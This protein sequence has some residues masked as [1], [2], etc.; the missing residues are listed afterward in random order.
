MKITSFRARNFRGFIDTSHIVLKPI[1]LLVGKNSIGKSS[2]ARLWPIFNQGSKLQKRSPVIWNGDLVDFGSFKNVLS[3]HTEEKEIIFEFKIQ[4][5][6]IDALPRKNIIKYRNRVRHLKSGEIIL[7]MKLIAGADESSTI[8]SEL[9]ISTHG[10]KIIYKFNEAGLL[11]ETSCDTINLKFTATYTQE[12]S[13]G[14]LIPITEFFVKSND[15]LLLAWSPMR[16][17]LYTFLRSKL[18]GRLADERIHEICGKLN[19]CGSEKDLL[20]YCEFLP[21]Q[22]KTWQD[23]LSLL[24]TNSSILT[25]FHLCVFLAV[26]ELLIRD[27][28]LDLHQ[29]FS[30]VNYIRPLRATAQRYYRRQDLAVDNIDSE[31][32]NL[33]FFLASLSSQKL[34]KLNEWLEE[35]IDVRVKLDGEQGHVMVTLEDINTGRVDNMADMGFGFSQ[36]L[37]LAV[38]AWISS[39]PFA[40]TSGRA[41]SNNMILVWEQPELHLHP[42]MQRKLARLIAKTIEVDAKK[43][44]SFIIETHS[45]SIINELGDLIIE[46]ESLSD[47]IQILIFDQIDKKETVISKTNFDTNGQLVDWPIGFLSV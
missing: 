16:S 2:F 21:Y 32:A 25:Q 42:A 46:D 45:Q 5:E 20:N 36:V 3:R 15:K 22:Y 28:D 4:I 19:V 24:R 26:S 11:L 31:G 6:E 12:R 34:E 9:S 40:K 10:L 41:T 1:N 7:Q 13:V 14:F 37:P 43:K 33:A 29:Y 18:H 44:V 39:S 8:C 27:I 30:Q 17:R 35:T 47:D 23:F 38:Q